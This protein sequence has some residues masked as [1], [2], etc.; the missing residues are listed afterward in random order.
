MILLKVSGVLFL[1]LVGV[2]AWIWFNPSVVV[3]ERVAAWALKKYVGPEL[4]YRELGVKAV[5]TGMWAKRIFVTAQG[6][7]YTVDPARKICVESLDLDALIDLYPKRIS[8]TVNHLF[9]D[10]GRVDWVEPDT[11]NAPPETEPKK[12]EPFSLPTLPTRLVGIPIVWGEVRVALDAANVEVSGFK[13][14]GQAK[15]AAPPGQRMAL[16]ADAKASQK[17]EKYEAR[18]TTSFDPARRASGTLSAAYLPKA[19]QKFAIDGCPFKFDWSDPKATTLGIECPL[20][21]RGVV[22]DKTDKTLREL[23]ESFGIKFKAAVRWEDF[24]DGKV[25]GKVTVAAGALPKRLADKAPLVNVNFDVDFGAQKEWEIHPSLTAQVPDFKR[26]VTFLKPT[27]WAIPVPLHVLDGK[28]EFATDPGVV[29]GVS[30]GKA[31]GKLVTTLSSLQQKFNTET[32]AVFEMAGGKTSLTLDAYLNKI[33]LVLPRV[34]KRPPPSFFPDSRIRAN[35]ERKPA[36]KGMELLV[37]VHTP[38]ESP[39]LLISDVT[40]TPIPVYVNLAVQGSA[41]TGSI[42]LGQV[43]AQFF[44]REAKLTRF[45]IQ[46]AERADL[47]QIRAEIQI[48]YTD[49]TIRILLMGLLKEPQVKLL[50]DPPLA[51]DQILAVLLFGKR[52]ESLDRSEAES[53]GSL[54]SAVSDGAVSLASMYLLASTPVESIGYDPVSRVFMAKIRLADGTSLNVGSDAKSLNQVGIRHRLGSNWA[55]MTYLSNPLDPVS[56]ALTAFLEW[57]RGY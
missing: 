13:I 30:G 25:T 5:A 20:V 45:E 46:L 53:A 11:A 4:V 28:I 36:S 35:F 16:V 22:P 39:I 56:R 47:N 18:L 10:G 40:K 26:L 52:P 32:T 42:R 7:C 19:S 23:L 2:A 29:W 37:R 43:T 14:V 6:A 54:R 51:E 55:I 34:E 50:S 33:Q 9:A 38:G 24:P 48:P 8:A 12:K 57:S 17:G 31:T 3:N 21:A 41:T 1:V 44:H 15:L 49:Y 27:P